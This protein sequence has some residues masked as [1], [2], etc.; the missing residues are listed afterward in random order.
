MFAVS[1]EMAPGSG[2]ALG[3]QVAL[4]GACVAGAGAV[5]GGA[6]FGVAPFA[7]LADAAVDGVGAGGDDGAVVVGVGVGGAGDGGEEGVRAVAVPAGGGAH[8]GGVDA[9]WAD[10]ADAGVAVL[11]VAGGAVDAP[12]VGVVA[13]EGL[14]DGVLAD[15]GVGVAEDVAD[16]VAGPLSDG[17]RLEDRSAVYCR[18]GLVANADLSVPLP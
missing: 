14:L 6:G 4:V 16:V 13:R 11:V 12:E 9:P 5:F 7:V 15:D 3:S 10:W 1:V 18:V 17:I 2:A 8:G